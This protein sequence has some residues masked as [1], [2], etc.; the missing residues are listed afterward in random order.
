M[1]QH[2]TVESGHGNGR[3]LAPIIKYIRLC[4]SKVPTMEKEK[5]SNIRCES[6]RP[7]YHDELR[8][9]YFCGIY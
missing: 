2:C 7:N 5:S 8:V 3:A 1:A 4:H 9:G 6:E